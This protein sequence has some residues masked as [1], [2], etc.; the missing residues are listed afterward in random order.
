MLLDN[1]KFLFHYSQ[2]KLS[3]WSPAKNFPDGFPFSQF[4]GV[5]T[6]SGNWKGLSFFLQLSGSISFALMF[7]R[8]GKN[9]WL[10]SSRENDIAHT[11][12]CRQHVVVVGCHLPEQLT[13]V[14]TR[15]LPRRGVISALKSIPFCQVSTMPFA[16]QQ[17]LWAKS[18]RS[19]GNFPVQSLTISWFGHGC[20][21]QTNKTTN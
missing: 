18:D 8:G 6:V 16:C 20:S 21:Q 11:T 12:W 13:I 2:T 4:T 5:W 19:L 9:F 14:C 1:K 17:L 3:P 7:W 10:E 15:F